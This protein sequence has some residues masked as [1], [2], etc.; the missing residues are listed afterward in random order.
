MDD[1]IFTGISPSLLRNWRSISML[2]SVS[3]ILLLLLSL[4]HIKRCIFDFSRLSLSPTRTKLKLFYECNM[5]TS[6]HILSTADR[7]TDRQ[8]GQIDIFIYTNQ[9]KSPTHQ[10]HHYKYLHFVLFSTDIVSECVHTL[11]GVILFLY[12]FSGT[13]NGH[14]LVRWRTTGH[15]YFE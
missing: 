13:D 7:Q 9:N 4:N 10:F 1:H 12:P 15:L 2:L 11:Y 14:K 3:L 6:I 5:Y 8:A